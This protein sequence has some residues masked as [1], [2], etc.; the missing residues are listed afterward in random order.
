[1]FTEETNISV[2]NCSEQK[3]QKSFEQKVETKNL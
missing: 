1:M 2:Y 3:N